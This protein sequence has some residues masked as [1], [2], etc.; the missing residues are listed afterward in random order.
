[1]D[2]INNTVRWY[3]EDSLHDLK[4]HCMGLVEKG[5]DMTVEESESL[6]K[7]LQEVSSLQTGSAEFEGCVVPFFYAIDDS[8]K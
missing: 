2:S 8:D 7:A 6:E 1:M 4:E 3:S 5:E